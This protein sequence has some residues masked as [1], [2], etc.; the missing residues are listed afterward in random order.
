M[1]FPRVFDSLF[2][3]LVQDERYAGVLG[4]GRAVE[5]DDM[6]LSLT[7]AA[8]FDAPL[9]VPGRFLIDHRPTI[10][11][12]QE[13]SWAEI[14]KTALHV[15][16]A[17]PTW[18]EFFAVCGGTPESP[19]LAMSSF[20]GR[21][22]DE[23]RMLWNGGRGYL[24]SRKAFATYHPDAVALLTILESNGFPVSELRQ[25]EPYRTCLKRRLTALHFGDKYG[26]LFDQFATRTGALRMAEQLESEFSPTRHAQLLNAVISA[27]HDE[28]A[29][30][31]P[32]T[33]LAEVAHGLP[34]ETPRVLEPEPLPGLGAI[35]EGNLTAEELLQVLNDPEVRLVRPRLRVARRLEDA[36]EVRACLHAI[37]TRVEALVGRNRSRVTAAAVIGGGASSL[38]ALTFVPAD[39]QWLAVSSSIFIML[40][41]FGQ[42][43]R[44][45]STE[46]LLY[47]PIGRHPLSQL[48]ALAL[49]RYGVAA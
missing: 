47:R 39:Y 24:E 25:G 1:I 5:P 33:A 43:I 11:L 35:L 2:D 32:E 20:G 22:N 38:A 10:A 40:L 48:E 13:K 16:T 9:V 19:P 18:S 42:G 14:A 23:I 37:G 46:K 21:F 29:T 44:V 45:T 7:V 8:L 6:K 41:G 49:K 34:A 28:V 36:A 26:R 30:T 3:D 4:L 15:L 17:E 31:T 12:L 27:K